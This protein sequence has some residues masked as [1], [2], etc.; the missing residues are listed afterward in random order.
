MSLEKRL[1]KKKVW[2]QCI[3]DMQTMVAQLQQEKAKMTQHKAELVQ[4]WEGR[5]A[6]QQNRLCDVQADLHKQRE[7]HQQR[8]REATERYSSTLPRLS[9]HN[10]ASRIALVRHEVQVLR[11]QVLLLLRSD[12]VE[13][14]PH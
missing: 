6:E 12:A 3:E 2:Q 10:T 5:C 7:Q 13:I 1:E 9:T 4:D 11:Q 14:H 8:M